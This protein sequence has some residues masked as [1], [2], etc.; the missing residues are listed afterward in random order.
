VLA[1][2]KAFNWLQSIVTRFSGDEGL[3]LFE[4]RLTVLRKEP[5]FPRPRKQNTNL[6]SSASFSVSLGRAGDLEVTGLLTNDTIP[7]FL[8]PSFLNSCSQ[9]TYGVHLIEV[10]VADEASL[11]SNYARYR[12]M[13]S[14]H[15]ITAY[16]TRSQ[17]NVCDCR[18]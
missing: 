12:T 9:M 18:I 7:C 4:A 3:E 14:V 13:Q 16:L 15:C 10:Y 17:F 8:R 6:K 11:I 1:A 5:S 2:V